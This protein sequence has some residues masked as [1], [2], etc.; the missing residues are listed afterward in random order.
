MAPV[1]SAQETRD[2]TSVF[3]QWNELGRRG[4]CIAKSLSSAHLIL[5][6]NCLPL[7]APRGEYP[8]PYHDFH[9]WK[10]VSG[11]W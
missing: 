10:G 8:Y 1:A 6:R 7:V 3:K 4:E 11:G 2:Y 9:T 5:P